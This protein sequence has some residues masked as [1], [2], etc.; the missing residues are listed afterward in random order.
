M[1]GVPLFRGSDATVAEEIK[2]DNHAVYELWMER[3]GDDNMVTSLTITYDSKQNSVDVTTS[4]DKAPMIA[5][6]GILA[7][8]RIK[9]EM[10]AFTMN[11]LTKPLTDFNVN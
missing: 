2:Q 8:G 11:G 7:A 10:Q 6:L 3:N 4:G 9:L 1:P 5:L